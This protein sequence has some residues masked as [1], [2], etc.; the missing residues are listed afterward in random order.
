MSFLYFAFDKAKY[1]RVIVVML[2]NEGRRMGWLKNVMFLYHNKSYL[3]DL[4]KIGFGRSYVNI[5]M[6]INVD[7]YI[8]GV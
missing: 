7:I 1:A 5:N 8:Q 2:R 6:Y 4:R 3:S